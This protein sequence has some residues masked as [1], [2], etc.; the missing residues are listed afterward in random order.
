MY[1]GVSVDRILGEV[2]LLEGDWH[3]AE[4]AFEDGLALCRRVNNQPEEAAILYEQARAALIRSSAEPSERSHRSLE[5]CIMCVIERASYF[6]AM[7]CR[8]LLTLSTRC[9]KV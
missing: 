4:Q 5:T 7:I 1:Y 3:R 9:K 8:E 2:A 6:Y